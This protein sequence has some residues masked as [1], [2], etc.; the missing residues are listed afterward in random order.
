MYELHCISSVVILNF[1]LMNPMQHM[2]MI[3]RCLK[4][5]DAVKKKKDCICDLANSYH[6]F[7]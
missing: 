2:S 3:L 6:I 1:V 4:I 7:L 5:K